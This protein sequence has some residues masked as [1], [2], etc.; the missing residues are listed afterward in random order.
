MQ[1]RHTTCQQQP[2]IGEGNGLPL[3]SNGVRSL[4][5]P[6]LPC[7]LALLVIMRSARGRSTTKQKPALQPAKE[8]PPPSLPHPRTKEVAE[9]S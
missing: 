5:K 9:N 2:S 1:V 4:A 3:G 6:A 7:C 8:P